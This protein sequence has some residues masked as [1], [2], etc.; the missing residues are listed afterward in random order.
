MALS[1][2]KLRKEIKNVFKKGRELRNDKPKY[3][4]NAIAQF[5]AAAIVDYA[6]DAEIQ[7]P[8]PSTLLTTT[9][10]PTVGIPDVAS[11]GQKLKVANPQ[12]GK[13]SLASSI[14]ASFNAMD[15]GMAIV[16]PA[17]VAYASTLFSFKNASGTITA[18]GVPV[19]A[20][21]PVLAPALAV[22][23]AKGAEDDVIKAM[24]TI[25]HISFKSTLFTGTGNIITPPAAGP[26][27]GTLM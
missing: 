18:T 25:I 26:V 5:F 24:A 23:A 7:I 17:V 22:G 2:A 6:S 11:S 9:P 15:V 8:A 16:T 1:E 14:A 4:K 19:M 12:P 21:P 13:A 3:S 27:V 10:T 20:I